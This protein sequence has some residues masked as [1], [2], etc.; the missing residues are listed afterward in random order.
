M[1]RATSCMYGGQ[2]RR[3]SV[4]PLLYGLRLLLAMCRAFGSIVCPPAVDLHYVGN[5][6]KHTLTAAFAS[7]PR[8]REWIN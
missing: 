3:E 4:R 1:Q 6:V 8:D 2:R 7:E 5:Y